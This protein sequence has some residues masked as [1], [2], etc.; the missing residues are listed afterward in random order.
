MLHILAIVV[1]AW[2]PFSYSN[3]ELD[4]INHLQRDNLQFVRPV[5]KVSDPVKVTFGFELVHIVSVTE[6]T[7]MIEMKIWIRMKWKSELLTWDPIQYG[8]VSTT[9]L[10]SEEVWTPDLFLMEDLNE[11]ISSGPERYKTQVIL[12]ADGTNYW[13]VPALIESSC[14]FDVTNFPFDKQFCKLKFVSWSYDQT[15]LD[16]IKDPRPIVT[17]ENYVVSSSWTLHSVTAKTVSQKYVCCPNSFVHIQYTVALHREPHYY[18]YNVVLPCIIQMLIILFTFFLPPDSGE[19]IS[20]A[21]TVLL[22]FAVYLEVLSSNLPKTS[23]SAPALSR[24]YISAMSGS[25]FSIMATCF[26]LVIHFKGAEKGVGP[27][28]KWVKD[29]FLDTLGVYML[30][31]KNMRVHKDEELLALEKHDSYTELKCVDNHIFDNS[32]PNGAANGL[33]KENNNMEKIVEEV[34]VIT[35]LIHDQNLQ[36]EIEEEWQSLGKVFDRIFFLVFL[37]FFVISSL[38]ILL[39]VYFAHIKDPE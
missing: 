7:Q 24:F 31:R 30:V 10:S 9:R 38:V 17:K 39:P 22:V 19:R 16:I 4:L 26:V 15:E 27:M 18:F 29:I 1:I 25:A 34:R 12:M 35:S 5:L 32:K 28:P 21:I 11:E 36:D 3:S 6:S 2:I 37:L 13:N 20:V 8:N 23:S 14:L 33:I